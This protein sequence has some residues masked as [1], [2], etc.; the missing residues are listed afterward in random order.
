[1]KKEICLRILLPLVI[2]RID[3]AKERQAT[4]YMRGDLAYWRD[5]KKQIKKDLKKYGKKD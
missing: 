4:C 1:M 5:I 3:Y 2:A